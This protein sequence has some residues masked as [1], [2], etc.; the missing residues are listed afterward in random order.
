MF[1]SRPNITP[2]GW[3]LVALPSPNGSRNFDAI[4]L[5]GR[6]VDFRFSSGWLT[7]S[8][9]APGVSD[10]DA[11]MEEV[12]SQPISF[13]GILDILPEQIC[14]ILGLTIQG[15]KVTAR[16]ISPLSGLFDWSGQTTY[17][18]STHRMMLYRDAEALTKKITRALPGSLLLQPLW[19]G[20]ALK[21]RCRQIKFLIKTDEIATIAIGFDKERVQEMLAAEEV[22]TA[23]YLKLLPYRIDITRADWNEDLTGKSFIDSR[24][25]DKLDLDYHVINHRRYRIHT[26]YPTDDTQAQ[27]MMKE[28]LEIIEHHFCRG[29]QVVN[30]QTADAIAE[31]F[32][33]EEDTRSYSRMFRGWCLERSDRYL[34]VDIYR[35][36]ENTPLDSRIFVG[37]LPI[38][39]CP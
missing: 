3:D 7:V 33:D 12:L 24:G 16:Q 39:R 15:K 36:P 21:L 30:L 31:D 17:W 2:L 27:S 37:Y 29:F 13:F 38:A 5:D 6:A 23:D 4:T 9:T 34:F 35:A 8:R 20:T 25:A 28:L 18:H 19:E 11:E 32:I 22:A 14:D 26:E 1:Y 10:P